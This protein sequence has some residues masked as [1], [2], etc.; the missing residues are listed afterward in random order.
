MRNG[1]PIHS[2]I[3]HV[4]LKQIKGENLDN[5]HTVSRM[6]GKNCSPPSDNACVD[7]KSLQSYP[8][9]CNPMDCRLL[10]SSVHGIFPNKNIGVGCHFN[11]QG[12]FPTQGLNLPL[13]YLLPWQVGSLLLAPPGKRLRG[14]EESLIWFK[15]T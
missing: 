6:Q 3:L 1:L 7:T 13:L 15:Q 4:L 9:L 12:I 14:I 8:A 10:G 11:L 5:L 2:I